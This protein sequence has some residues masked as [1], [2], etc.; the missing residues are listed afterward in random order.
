MTLTAYSENY[1]SNHLKEFYDTSIF[2]DFCVYVGKV[3]DQYTKC[4]NCHKVI[5]AQCQYFRSLWFNSWGGDKNKEN[6]SILNFIDE[7][8]T[9]DTYDRFFTLL[10][11]TESIQCENMREVLGLYR[12][13]NILGFD[14]GIKQCFSKILVLMNEDNIRETLNFA[15][16]NYFIDLQR[17]CYNWLSICIYFIDNEKRESL[18]A[19]LTDEEKE[20][21]LTNECILNPQVSLDNTFQL[22][23]LY[24]FSTVDNTRHIGKVVAYNINNLKIE[25]IIKI[26][27]PRHSIKLYYAI[28]NTSNFDTNFL[29]GSETIVYTTLFNCSSKIENHHYIQSNK[30]II[31]DAS[32]DLRHEHI[33]NNLLNVSQ[34]GHVIGLKLYNKVIYL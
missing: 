24:N 15:L 20:S 18:C 17:H 1:F 29:L 14:R 22:F 11:S 25:V 30:R 21:I 3:D 27:K 23:T 10:Y 4:Y 32:I 19:M 33:V 16:L 26:D 34:I 31:T 6:A 12:L 13:C 2:S 7:E 5:L 8:I 9:I 28:T